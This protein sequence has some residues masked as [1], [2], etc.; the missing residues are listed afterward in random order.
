M[1]KTFNIMFTTAN[2]EPNGVFT[3]TW[4]QGQHNNPMK[5]PDP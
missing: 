2:A 5:C 1:I 4:P 3:P